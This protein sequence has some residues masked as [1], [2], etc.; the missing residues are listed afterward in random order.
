MLYVS[1][2]FTCLYFCYVTT[3]FIWLNGEPNITFRNYSTKMYDY[4]LYFKMFSSIELVTLS[5]QFIYA[6]QLEKKRMSEMGN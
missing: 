3:Y 4:V 6:Q 5:C 1:L 2:K